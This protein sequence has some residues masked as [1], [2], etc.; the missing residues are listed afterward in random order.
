M[1]AVAEEFEL[2]DFRFKIPSTSDHYFSHALLTVA[3]GLMLWLSAVVEGFELSPSD[4]EL[5]LVRSVKSSH[6]RAFLYIGRR[7]VDFSIVLSLLEL[8]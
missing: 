7:E 8:S 2:L 3:D 4:P 1:S 6:V 5:F